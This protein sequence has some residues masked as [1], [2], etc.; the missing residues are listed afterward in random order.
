VRVCKE[1]RSPVTGH[2]SRVTDVNVLTD[3]FLQLK[4]GGVPVSVKEY[5]MLGEIG[6]GLAFHHS[7]LNF[8]LRLYPSRPC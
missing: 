7:D 2:Q 6:S 8:S 3:F 4:S 5:L 1:R